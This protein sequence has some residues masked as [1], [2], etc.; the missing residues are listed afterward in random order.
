MASILVLFWSPASFGL[1]PIKMI[2]LRKTLARRQLN[3]F[4]DIL[5]ELETQGRPACRGFCSGAHG[6]EEDLLAEAINAAAEAAVQASNS[7]AD[8]RAGLLDPSTEIGAHALRSAARVK[9]LAKPAK[10]R[11]DTE[12]LEQA[13]VEAGSSQVFKRF[14]ASLSFNDK[15]L[16]RIYRCGA[17]RTPTRRHR[18]PEQRACPFCMFPDASARHFWQDCDRF[19][20]TRTDLCIEF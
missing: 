8:A 4:K 20:A 3:L 5:Q 14:V 1:L 7:A 18:V 13:D 10:G 9:A 17:I 19:S 6:R 15:V 12:G 2:P 11:F 16:L